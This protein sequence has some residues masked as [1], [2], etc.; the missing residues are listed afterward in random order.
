MSDGTTIEWT[1]RP[2][3]KG[4]TWNPIRARHL[5]TG[6]IGWH[7]ETVSD[8]CKFCY[9]AAQNLNK[10][11]LAFGTGLPYKPG[12]RRDLAIFVDHKTLT[13]PLRWRD[14]RTIFVCSMTDAFGS[15]VDD[16]M[17]DRM[18][19]VAAL[20]PQHVFIFVT[21]RARRMR[22]Y[23]SGFTCDGAR[24]LNVAAAAGKLMED[25]DNAHDEVANAPWPLPNVWLIVSTEDQAAADER[26]PELLA[27]PAA[28]RGVSAEPLLGPINFEPWLDW[29]DVG[30]HADVPEVFG[31]LW[32]CQECDTHCPDCP[33]GKAEYRVEEGPRDPD[34]APEWVT[35]ER[36]TLDWIIA[37]GESGDNARPMH[38]DWARSLRDQCAAAR[39][40][41]FFKQWGAWGWSPEWMDFGQGAAWAKSTGAKR[42]EQHSSGHTAMF[43]GKRSA[44]RT[45]DGRE[46][47]AFPEARAA[48]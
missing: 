35:A 5:S 6:K 47:D 23:V 32:G 45:L 21:K 30:I 20:C 18:F 36:V 37:G 40:A 38:P 22:E 1:H 17:L 44:G 42:F 48:S 10:R 26:I 12:H 27:T 24:R 41:F 11:N 34:G 28:V 16:Y 13:A 7:C 33:R 4:E 39:T 25:G 19:A 9:A 29:P 43:L 31:A 2:G 8:G 3:T 15:F 14:P 46:H